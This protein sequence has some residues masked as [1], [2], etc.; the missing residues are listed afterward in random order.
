MIRRM[1]RKER[2][3]ATRT[4]GREERKGGEKE[5]RK[6]GCTAGQERKD[7]RKESGTEKEV[8]EDGEKNKE[9]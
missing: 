2:E 6:E 5:G 9:R 4:G 3:E 1:K 8:M 7:R